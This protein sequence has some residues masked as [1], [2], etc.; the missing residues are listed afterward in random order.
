MKNL[1]KDYIYKINDR[2]NIYYAI[3]I[4][5][6]EG[7][8]CI[9]CDKGHNAYSFNIIGYKNNTL[10]SSIEEFEKGYWETFSYGKEHFP[11]IIECYGSYFK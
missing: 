7:A 10:E 2:G 5:R 6:Q 9:V 8:E 3:Y 4:G 11:S 1:K